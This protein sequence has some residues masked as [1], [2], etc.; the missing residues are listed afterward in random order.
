MFGVEPDTWQIEALQAHDN[1]EDVAIR[2]GHGVGKTALLAWI[3]IHDLACFPYAKIPCTAPTGHQLRDLLWAEIGMWLARSPLKEWLKWTATT[4]QAVG[5]E[6]SW[7]A[8][9]RACS[10]PENLAGFHA[11][12]CVYIVDEG[13][14]VADNIFQVVDGA[15][16]TSGAQLVMAGNPTSMGGYFHDAFFKNRSQWH[17]VHVSSE[18]SNRVEPAYCETMAAKW[19][20]DSDIYKVRVL[21][22]F[23]DAQ[24]DSFIPLSSVE[25]A[26]R[27]WQDML[28]GTPV[29]IGVDVARY[30][31]DETVFVTRAGNKVIAIERHNGWS[32]TATAGRCVQL[33]REHGASSVAIDDSG[34]GGG[35]TDMLNESMPVEFPTCAVIPMNFGGPGDDDY[36]NMTG[37]MYGRIKELLRIAAL[38]LPDD[39]DLIAQ[40]TTR[41]YRLTSKGKLELERKDEMKRRGLQSPDIADALVL[42]MWDEMTDFEAVKSSGVRRESMGEHTIW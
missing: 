5:Y 33:A 20:R 27:L 10:V 19:G 21:G 7:F 39:E 9:A 38:G 36:S 15:M 23:P 30:G 34:V 18:Q 28:P 4:V 22:D 1:G 16:T 26:V 40:L 6:E 41:K 17:T 42:A 3:V 8:V 29:I 13:S 2:S 31:D 32:T 24:T 37:R 25:Q 14:G 11:P 35:V 12:K